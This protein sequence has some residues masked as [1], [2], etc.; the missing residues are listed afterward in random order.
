MV[1]HIVDT[2]RT[3]LLN[4]PVH[5]N[6]GKVVRFIPVEANEHSENLCRECKRRHDNAAIKSALSFAVRE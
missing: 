2:D 6:C 4:T 5:A 3:E 1:I